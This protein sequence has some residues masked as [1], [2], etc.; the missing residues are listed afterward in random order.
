MAYTKASRNNLRANNITTGSKS[1]DVELSI[2]TPEG[3]YVCQTGKVYNDKLSTIQDLDTSIIKLST[4]DKDKGALTVQNARAIVIKNLSNI[5][6]E[7]FITV[8]D[9]KNDSGT[10]T[11]VYNS[12]DVGGGGATAFRTMTMLLQGGEFLYLLTI[13][14]IS[15]SQNAQ[16]TFESGTN[17]AAGRVTIEPKDINSGNEYVDMHLFSGSTYNSGADI[18]IA[19]AVAISDVEIDVDDGDWFKVNDTIMIGSEVMRVQSV[20]TNTLTVQR[21]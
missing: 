5:T 12:V 1:A 2:S 19:E 9:W 15:Y 13:R 21:G 14:L 4:F 7:I 10:T 20:A 17:S 6:A 11:D 3:D 18:Q 8:H 16:A